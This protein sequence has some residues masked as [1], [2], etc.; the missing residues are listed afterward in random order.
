MELALRVRMLLNPQPVPWDEA[1]VA[2]HRAERQTKGRLRYPSY[3]YGMFAAAR[4]AVAVGYDS[5]SAI[6]FGVAGG[7]GLS[8]LEEHAAT[9]EAMFPLRVS[10]FGFDT[11]AGLPNATDPRDCAF[12]LKPGAFAMDEQK[13]RNKLHRSELIIG[14]VEESVVPFMERSRSGEIPPIGFIVQDLDV[15]TGTHATLNELQ[16]NPQV[17]PRVSMYFDDLTGYPY[18]TEVG[19]WAAIRAFNESGSRKIGQVANL[20]LALGGT[21]RFATWPRQFFVLHAFDH[22]KYNAPEEIRFPDLRLR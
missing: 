6:E 14:P 2:L 16:D 10:V 22:P 3:L 11:G 20:D 21:A 7:N 17:L 4:T 15:F 8:A 1:A 19:E 18:T 12:A 13:L 5:F 9:I